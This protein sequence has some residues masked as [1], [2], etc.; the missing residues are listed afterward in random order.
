MVNTD[1]DLIQ[2]TGIFL[3]ATHK[4]SYDLDLLG[5]ETGSP[6]EL[7][8]DDNFSFWVASSNVM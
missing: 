5:K 6:W 4:G 3:L 1:N 7:T 2:E 8:I